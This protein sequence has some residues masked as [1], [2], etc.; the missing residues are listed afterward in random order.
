MQITE[1][2]FNIAFHRKQAWKCN[3]F[4][5]PFKSLTIILPLILFF[6]FN[7]WSIITVIIAELLL[8][9]LSVKMKSLRDI[10]MF[11]VEEFKKRHQLD[12]NNI[13][14]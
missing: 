9:L 3:V 2:Q 12:L 4:Y 10:N 8:Y 11:A 6:F 7:L 1:N 5:Y 13:F 14:K